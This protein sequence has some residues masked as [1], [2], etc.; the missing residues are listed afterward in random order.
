MA[1]QCYFHMGNFERAAKETLKVAVLSPKG[2]LVFP[3]LLEAGKCFEKLERW[4]EATKLYREIVSKQA[5]STWAQTANTRLAAIQN[6][7]VK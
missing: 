3:A 4:N 7:M 6:R 5:K 2:P 1:G